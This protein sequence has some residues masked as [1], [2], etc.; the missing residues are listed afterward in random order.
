MQL[1]R[2]AWSDEGGVLWIEMTEEHRLET[3]ATRRAD[4]A[5]QEPTSL[6]CRAKLPPIVW[7][8]CATRFCR[9]ISGSQVRESEVIVMLN[10]IGA[11]ALLALFANSERFRRDDLEKVE[12]RLATPPNTTAALS[13]V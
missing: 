2:C 6:R 12:V 7:R 9:K 10:I 11:L 5:F 3:K 8:G 13:F 4:S 1:R